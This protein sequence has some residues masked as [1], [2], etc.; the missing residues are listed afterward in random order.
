M[1][2]TGMQF[3]YGMLFVSKLRKKSPYIT[4]VLHLQ[5][6]SYICI[7]VVLAPDPL[8]RKQNLKMREKEELDPH[9]RWKVTPTSSIVHHLH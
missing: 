4:R 5:M 7:N 8:T 6:Q 3:C 2:R 1:F 9:Y